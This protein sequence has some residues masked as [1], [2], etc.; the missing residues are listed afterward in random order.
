MNKT[1]SFIH[2]V[3]KASHPEAQGLA[4][5]IHEWLCSKGITVSIK[6]NG[7]KGGEIDLEVPEDAQ[8]VLILGGDGTMLSVARKLIGREIPVLAVNLGKVGFLTEVSADTWKEQLSLLL[9]GDY[10]LQKR[11]TLAC[12]VTRGGDSVFNAVAV[13]D[14]VIHR[15]ALARVI[16]LDLAVDD[17]PVVALRADGLIFSSPTGSTGYA[18]SAGGPLLFPEVHA[19][20]VTP[21]CPFINNFKPMVL[22][23]DTIF[24]AKLSGTGMDVFLTQDGQEAFLLKPGDKVTIRCVRESLPLVALEGSSYFAK[25]RAKGFIVNPAFRAGEES[26]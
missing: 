22:A 25:L 23:G 24:S 20:S 4:S 3:T 1:I 5:A 11:S 8:C 10:R 19:Y 17:E 9:Q 7:I 16:M 15:G 26:S 12:T 14:L 2:I 21:I 13:N 18:V 6:E